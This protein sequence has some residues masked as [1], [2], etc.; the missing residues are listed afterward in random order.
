MSGM[1]MMELIELAIS[2]EI[3]AN[4]I[5]RDLAGRMDDT[6]VRETFE[7][8]AK[9]EW[10][11]KTF[12]EDYRDGN[13]SQSLALNSVVDYKIAEHIEKPQVLEHMSIKDAY[14]IAAHAEL[15]AYNLYMD[16]ASSHEEGYAKN[17]LL[18]MANE[19]KKHKEKVEY[20][21][22]NAAF[23]QDSGG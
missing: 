15:D 21:Y 19:E 18:K 23:P 2:K 14:L 12:L 1:I 3:E 6:A 8:L 17:L 5:Y 11:H 20:Y 7:F 9:E 13:V 4:E 16:L 10:K 22:T